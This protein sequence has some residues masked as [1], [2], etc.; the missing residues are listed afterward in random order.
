MRSLR[1]RLLN[2]IWGLQ[3]PVQRMNFVPFHTVPTGSYRIHVF[4][5]GCALTACLAPPRGQAAA[6]PLLLERAADSAGALVASSTEFYYTSV[7]VLQL[8]MLWETMSHHYNIQQ[9]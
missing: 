8:C 6:T 2:Q 7:T 1:R 4:F 3:N 9:Q 5:N